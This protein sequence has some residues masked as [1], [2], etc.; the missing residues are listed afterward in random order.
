MLLCHSLLVQ[1]RF[2]HKVRAL[3]HGWCTQWGCQMSLDLK[4]GSE[5]AYL[6]QVMLIHTQTHVMMRKLRKPYVF[7]LYVNFCEEKILYMSDFLQN[8]HFGD[9]HEAFSILTD[10]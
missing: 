2:S 3:V 5:L 8:K 10:I 1:L 4:I 6:K 9:S 7:Y